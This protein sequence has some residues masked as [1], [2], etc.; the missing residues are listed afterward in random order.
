MRLALKKTYDAVPEPKI[1]IALGAC[2]ISGGPYVGHAEVHDGANSVVPVDLYIPGC[3]PHP[4]TI[5]D[6]LL[7]LLGRIDAHGD[8][9]WAERARATAESIGEDNERNAREWGTRR[10]DEAVKSVGAD[11]RDDEQSGRSSRG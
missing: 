10:A 2:A 4:F 3:P 11:I 8:G 6:G 9:T 7:G 1:V 5:L